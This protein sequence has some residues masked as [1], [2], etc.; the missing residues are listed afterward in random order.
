[1]S[2]FLTRRR[3]GGVCVSRPHL[4]NVST[5]I[6]GVRVFEQKNGEDE[7]ELSL[8]CIDGNHNRVSMC[9]L[10]LVRGETT[11]LRNA[12]YDVFGRNGEMI[13]EDDTR[14]VFKLL[15]S[16]DP[17]LLDLVASV[18]FAFLTVRE[19]AVTRCV[20]IDVCYEMYGTGI[21]VLL[22][23]N[24]KIISCMNSDDRNDLSTGG[25]KTEHGFGPCKIIL[26]AKGRILEDQND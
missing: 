1:M 6:L 3:V 12:L 4:R 19:D 17:S 16:I 23:N 15:Q 18:T 13:K 25:V 26:A 8:V 2:F 22:V 14:G 11:L 10:F 20:F 7:A 5:D 21:D 9:A 24:G